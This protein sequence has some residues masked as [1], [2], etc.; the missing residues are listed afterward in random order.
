MQ[1]TLDFEEGGTPN[2]PHQSVGY[3]LVRARSPH[4]G[5]VRMFGA[6]Y[7]NDYS[8]HYEYGCS[9]CEDRG[10]E[11]CPLANGN[12]CPTTGWF[13]E[14]THPDFE[15]VYERLSGEVIAFCKP[16]EPTTI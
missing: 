15:T 11:N 16:P 14:V 10:E 12:G 13:D 5:M 6:Y 4:D 1:I 9:E 2:V 7:M 8:L 3:Y